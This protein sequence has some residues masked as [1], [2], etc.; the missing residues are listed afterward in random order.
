MR[1]A[2]DLGVDIITVTHDLLP[3]LALFG[4]SLDDFSLDT[5]RMFHDDAQAAGFT[6]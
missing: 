2:D 1:Q 6:L 4:R 3:K 5:V